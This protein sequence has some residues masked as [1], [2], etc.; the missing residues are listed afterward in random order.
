M[1][2]V[3]GEHRVRCDR[4]DVRKHALYRARAWLFD[5]ILERL[6]TL[7]VRPVLRLLKRMKRGDDGADAEQGEKFLG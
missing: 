5:L 7:V 4:V 1:V 6:W 2:V 3:D